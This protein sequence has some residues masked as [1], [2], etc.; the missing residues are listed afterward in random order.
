MV[1]EADYV[2]VSMSELLKPAYFRV[3]ASGALSWRSF[4]NF[5]KPQTIP[6]ARHTLLRTPLYD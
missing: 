6:L 5:H 2:G 3:T 1:D 4:Y